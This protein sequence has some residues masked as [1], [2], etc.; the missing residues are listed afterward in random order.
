MEGVERT[1]RNRKRLHHATAQRMKSKFLLSWTSCSSPLGKR[2]PA[3][4]FA[5]RDRTRRRRLGQ[6]QIGQPALG[7]QLQGHRCSHRRQ[8]PAVGGTRA[9]TCLDVDRKAAAHQRFPQ[10]CTWSRRFSAG[11]RKCRRATPRH[12]CFPGAQT[13]LTKPPLASS[14]APSTARGS[15]RAPKTGGGPACLPPSARFPKQS[16]GALTGR[17]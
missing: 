6:G 17:K 13:R 1:E 10:G 15:R 14:S 7:F 8:M 3:H 4:L 5:E 11:P 16:R 12:V 9:A 2:F